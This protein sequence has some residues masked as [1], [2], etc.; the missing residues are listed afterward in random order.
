MMVHLLFNQSYSFFGMWNVVKIAFNPG[1][2]TIVNNSTLKV[3]YPKG[4][5][6]PSRYPQGG[7][8]FFSSPPQIFLAEEVILNYTFKFDKS[9][10]PMFGGKLPGLFIGNSINK[11]SMINASGGKYVNDTTASCRLAWRAGFGAEAYLYLPTKNQHHDY[12]KIPGLVLNNKYGDSLWRNLLH[13]D[14]NNWNHISIHL[15]LNNI[16]TIGPQPDG[17]LSIKIHSKSH[18]KHYSFNKIIWRTKPDYFIN[19]ILFET[20]FGGSTNKYATPHD[21][22]TY[23][24]DVSIQKIK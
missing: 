8:G 24:K 7:I 20:F 19:S 10:N 4:S 13:F 14:K 12:Y 11:T 18:Y 17:V 23:F 22:W 6:S 9:F 5:F 3:Y 16:N 2:N 1:N 21:T 15:K